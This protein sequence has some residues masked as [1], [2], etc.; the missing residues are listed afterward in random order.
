MRR[1]RRWCKVVIR[2]NLSLYRSRICLF[3]RNRLDPLRLSQAAFVVF[4]ESVGV[5]A[6]VSSPPASPRRGAI[7]TN[8]LPTGRGETASQASP[9]G[10]VRAP[11][12]ARTGAS[13]PSAP[14]DRP[15]AAH[16]ADLAG[17]SKT[18]PPSIA[19]SL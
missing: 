8:R 14:R 11:S 6:I 1:Q 10:P 19:R 7:G 16:P 4:E 17:T 9:S 15:P 12:A 13:T 5:I 3:Q 18:S 2:K